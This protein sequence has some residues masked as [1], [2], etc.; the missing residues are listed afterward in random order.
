MHF[1]K[2]SSG[3]RAIEI[4]LGL[5]AL[6]VGFLALFFPTAV[7]VTIVVLFGIALVVIGILRL[8]TV[9]STRSL[10]GSTR[11]ANAVIGALALIIGLVILFFPLIAAETIVILIGIGL[12]IY[13]IGRL[14]VG[15]AANNLSGALRAV[16]ILTGVLV[17]IFAIIIILFPVVGVYTYAFFVSLSFIFIGIDSLASGILGISLT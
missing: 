4:I 7:V 8:A 10:Y 12:L 9:A 16:I 6:T 2:S 11:A 17:A 14:A 13:A 15:G 1:A 3:Y 5:V